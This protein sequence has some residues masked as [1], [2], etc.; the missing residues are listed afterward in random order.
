MVS[1]AVRMMTKTSAV[2]TARR[3]GAVAVWLVVCLSALI[4]IVA[5][6]MDGGRMMD[7]RRRAR[8]AAD[9]AA[10]AAALASAS[11]NGYAND[12]STSVVT[13]NIPPLAGPFAGQPDYAEVII[14][15]K[16]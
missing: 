11:A 13:V 9:A 10:L 12:G 2:A 8:A 4:G 1:G 6:G 5:L 7:E 3:T 14:K 15:S 16:L